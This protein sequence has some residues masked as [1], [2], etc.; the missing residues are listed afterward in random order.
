M[1][2]SSKDQEHRKPPRKRTIEIEGENPEEAWYLPT[3]EELEAAKKEIRKEWDDQT[4]K[5]RR[6]GYLPERHTRYTVPVVKNL[7]DKK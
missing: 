3:H 4:E 7:I 6:V 5:R 2:K 1:S